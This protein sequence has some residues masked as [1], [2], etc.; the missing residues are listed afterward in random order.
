MQDEIV[1]AEKEQE[2]FKKV[3]LHTELGHQIAERQQKKVADT[4]ERKLK[5]MTSGGPVMEAED[6]ESINKKFRLQQ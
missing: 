6:I 3:Q 1:N 5:V 2:K 4:M